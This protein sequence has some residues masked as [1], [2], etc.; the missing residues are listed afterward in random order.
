MNC[1]EYADKQLEDVLLGDPSLYEHEDQ[2]GSR[3]YEYDVK[4]NSNGDWIEMS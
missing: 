4:Y 3:R 1:I 2:R